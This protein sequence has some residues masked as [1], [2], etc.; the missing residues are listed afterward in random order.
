M[1]RNRV[2]RRNSFIRR[3]KRS[4][5]QEAC[6]LIL[7]GFC[8]FFDL[9]RLESVGRRDQ[10]QDVFSACGFGGGIRG[11]AL[12]QKIKLNILITSVCCVVLQSDFARHYRISVYFLCSSK[13]PNNVNEIHFQI[14]HICQY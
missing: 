12:T 4:N 7:E 8:F 10:N 6:G 13:N 5:R 2:R 9:F 3:E 14:Y 11:N 1:R